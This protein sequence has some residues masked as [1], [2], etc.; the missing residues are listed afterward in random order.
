MVSMTN[1][2]RRHRPTGTALPAPVDWKRRV[3][4]R[5]KEEGWTQEDL[6]RRLPAGTQ[7]AVSLLLNSDQPSSRLVEPISKLL[8][9]P[10]PI[11]TIDSA[12]ED[13]WKKVGDKL[14][15]TN[16][17]RYIRILEKLERAAEAEGDLR[18]ADQAL[19]EDL[20]D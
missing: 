6:A 8:G 5:L 17:P 14:K 1:R 7:S 3:R 16:S 19:K 15:S 4:A 18:E 13:R 12:D 11:A 9:I 20:P 2:K 10:V